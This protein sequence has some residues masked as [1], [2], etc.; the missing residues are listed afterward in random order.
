MTKIYRVI[1]ILLLTLISCNEQQRKKA[2]QKTREF[3]KAEIKGTIVKISS[4]TMGYYVKVDN[5]FKEYGFVYKPESN[6]PSLNNFALKGD[7][8]IKKTNSSSFTIKKS[9]GTRHTY[10]LNMNFSY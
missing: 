8:L 10:S 9:N 6:K 7:S 4:S 5:D 1:I 2:E 3:Y